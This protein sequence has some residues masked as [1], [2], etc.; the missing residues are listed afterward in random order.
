MA[1]IFN[2]LVR[3]SQS[4]TKYIYSFQVRKETK[5]ER[6]PEISK[7]PPTFIIM[8]MEYKQHY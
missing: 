3:T 6:W 1:I 5:M 2:L 8:I 4:I 7:K